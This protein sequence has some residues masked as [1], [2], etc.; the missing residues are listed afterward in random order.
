MTSIG[1]VDFISIEWW[2]HFFS[3]FSLLPPPPRPPLLIPSSPFLPVF[4]FPI[5]ALPPFLKS[6]LPI[7]FSPFLLPYMPKICSIASKKNYSWK[8]RYFT[9]SPEISLSVQNHTF[10]ADVCTPRQY[11]LR[12]CNQCI[13]KRIAVIFTAHTLWRATFCLKYELTSKKK[14]LPSFPSFL[15]L[16][17]LFLSLFFLLVTRQGGGGGAVCPPCPPRRYATVAKS[18]FDQDQVQ[19]QFI[20]ENI[21]SVESQKGVITIQRFPVEKQ[22]GTIAINFYSDTAPFWFSTERRWIVIT[23]YRHECV[24]TTH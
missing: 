1:S 5:W 8:F 19:C 24:S 7:T 6:P 2:G 22:K 11:R 4:P 14:N 21:P 3:P 10:Y 12:I 18:F 9:S 13:S 17:L 23:P 16:L 20:S 15:L